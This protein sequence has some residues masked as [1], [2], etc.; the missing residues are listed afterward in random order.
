MA[1][2][3]RTVA[4]ELRGS[5]VP[6]NTTPPDIAEFALRA[7]DAAF[8]TDRSRQMVRRGGT[9][10]DDDGGGAGVAQSQD[11]PGGNGHTAKRITAGAEKPGHGA[12]EQRQET[13]TVISGGEKVHDRTE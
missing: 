8:G 7:I 5:D 2:H 11:P 3:L 9:S 10:G 12:S 1:D 13:E 4:K 6:A